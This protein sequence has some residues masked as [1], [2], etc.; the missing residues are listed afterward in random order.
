MWYIRYSEVRYKR[1]LCDELEV[2]LSVI[3]S[4]YLR[5]DNLPQS[6]EENLSYLEDRC[7]QH[8]L[9]L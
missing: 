9:S 1:Q 5:T 2:A 4:S 8:L 7:G 6:V 3:T